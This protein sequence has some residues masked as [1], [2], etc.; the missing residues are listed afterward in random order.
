M[1]QN[2]NCTLSYLWQVL[3]HTVQVTKG[4]KEANKKVLLKRHRSS[5][6]KEKYKFKGKKEK[7]KKGGIR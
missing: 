6:R 5:F 3:I 7:K 4:N 2:K 1:N